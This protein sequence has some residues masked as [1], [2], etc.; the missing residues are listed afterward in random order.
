MFRLLNLLLPLVSSMILGALYARY[1]FYHCPCVHSYKERE[2]YTSLAYAYI[3]LAICDI[4]LVSCLLSVGLD[5]FDM[6]ILCEIDHAN[7]VSCN[8]LQTVDIYIY[9]TSSSANN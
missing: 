1:Y 6:P 5:V 4:Y 7:N 2:W 3:N 8:A 9:C